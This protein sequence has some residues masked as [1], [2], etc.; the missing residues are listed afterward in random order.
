M[1]AETSG[2]LSLLLAKG[3][4]PKTLSG[5][6]DRLVEQGVPIAELARLSPAELVRHY[7]L[8]QDVAE[9]IPAAHQRAEQVTEELAQHGV[10]I[11]IRGIEPYPVNLFEVLGKEA[12]PV[13]FARGNIS[14]LSKRAVGFCGA[15][16]AS[17]KG[18][19][20][21]GDSARLL[22]ARGVN[23]VSGYA[24]GVDLAAH[25]AALGAGGVTTI[26]LAEG[27]LHFRAKREVRDLLS[28]EN[29]LVISEFSPRLPWA[30]HNAMQRNRTICGLSDAFIVVESGMKGGTFAAAETA[31]TLKRRL[32]VADYA[33]PSESAAGNKHFISRGAI[34][35]RGNESGQP[36]LRRVYEALGIPENAAEPPH[37]RES[38]PQSKIK[39]CEDV[40]PP[41]PTPKCLPLG[42]DNQVE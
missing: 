28:D 36:N 10:Q 27:I 34:P 29:H 39:A 7:G 16:N 38:E 18:V 9:A 5:L 37:Q 33:Q 2:I 3:V 41:S 32:F 21:A 35:L 14:I 20:V 40:L 30:V 42:F 11:L 26:V 24:K 8:R 1:I 17:E 22:A 4:G 19:R 31:L 23:I 6:V 13:L 25:E 12:P 15:R